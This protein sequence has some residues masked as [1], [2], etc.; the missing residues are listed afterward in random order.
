HIGIKVYSRNQLIDWTSKVAERGVQFQ[1]MD[2]VACCYADQS[3]IYMNDPDGVLFEVYNVNRD[4]EPAATARPSVS[5]GICD[6]NSKS[7][8]HVLPSEF[9]ERLNMQGNSLEVVS[10]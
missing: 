3:K 9:P 1:H 6:A 5:Q 8:D 4:L 10:L 2:N 7:Y